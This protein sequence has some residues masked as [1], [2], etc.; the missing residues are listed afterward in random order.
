[1]Y[2]DSFCIIAETDTKSSEQLT[3]CNINDNCGHQSNQD[4]S[5]TSII[6]PQP[7]TVDEQDVTPPSSPTNEIAPEIASNVNTPLPQNS[8]SFEEH[9]Q[10]IDRIEAQMSS[11]KNHMKCKLSTM[12]SKIDSLSELRYTKINNLNDQQKILET[13]RENIKLLQM[14]LQ[15]KNDIIKN[16]LDTQ[17]AVVE[18]LSHSKDQ[19]N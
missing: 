12:S 9:Q 14:E 10:F 4:D 19:Q 13:L 1:M 2:G 5:G 6:N 3:F 7:F 17:S 11:L 16:L 18:S 8:T 15:T